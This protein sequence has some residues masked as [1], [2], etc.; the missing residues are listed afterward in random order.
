ML[1]LTLIGR[2]R[3]GLLLS[4]SVQEDEQVVSA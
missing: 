2:L 1:L 4:A 3:D